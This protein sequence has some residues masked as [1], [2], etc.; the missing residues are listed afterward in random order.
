MVVLGTNRK[1]YKGVIMM[2]EMGN[3]GSVDLITRLVGVCEKG[4]GWIDGMCI[5]DIMFF[6]V[7]VGG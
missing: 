2:K 6:N 3:H 1:S 7:A 4:C 5:N